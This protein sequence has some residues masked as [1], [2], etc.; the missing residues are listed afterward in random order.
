V[1]CWNPLFWPIS[2]SEMFNFASHFPETI[3]IIE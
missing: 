1:G 2:I 3:I